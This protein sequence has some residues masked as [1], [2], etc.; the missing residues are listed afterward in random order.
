MG[1]VCGNIGPIADC[2]AVNGHPD[3]ARR[4][5]Y[6]PRNRYVLVR[7]IPTRLNAAISGP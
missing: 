2:E 7:R 6:G 1:L 3:R 4:R 5:D